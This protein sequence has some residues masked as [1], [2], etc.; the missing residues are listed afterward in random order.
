MRDGP[1]LH[2]AARTVS[3]A[4]ADRGAVSDAVQ[5]SAETLP[6]ITFARPRSTGASTSAAR[7]RSAR[8]ETQL[9]AAAGRGSDASTLATRS[10]SPA[11][12]ANVPGR[13]PA[14]RAYDSTS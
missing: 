9:V 12:P 11:R 14:A 7:I 6:S 5:R 13:E 3:R 2:Q 4:R 8:S 1:Y 10:P